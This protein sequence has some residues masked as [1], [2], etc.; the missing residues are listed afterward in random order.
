MGGC[1]VHHA[2]ATR[3]AATF[4][5]ERRPPHES[6]RVGDRVRLVLLDGLAVEG[7]VVAADDAALELKT[8][9]EAGTQRVS[10]VEIGTI[11]PAGRS[12]AEF[13][14]AAMRVVTVVLLVALYV[15]IVAFQFV[16]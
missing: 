7:F 9:D 10:A 12:H 4:C 14:E 1:G 11:E 6:P 5:L 13:G 15:S 16:C 2:Y 3:D 8:E